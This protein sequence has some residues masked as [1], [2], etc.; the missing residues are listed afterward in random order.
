VK[1]W[2]GLL[3]VLVATLTTSCENLNL[4]KAPV[5]KWEADSY[6]QT[7]QKIILAHGDGAIQ[8]TTSVKQRILANETT[9]RCLCEKEVGPQCPTK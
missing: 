1:F 6:C 8:A 7:Y 2:T 9:Y 3:L 4:G 5:P